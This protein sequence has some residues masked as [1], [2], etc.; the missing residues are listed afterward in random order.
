MP[1]VNATLCLPFTQVEQII[2]VLTETVHEA[3]QRTCFPYLEEADE[4]MSGLEDILYP[5]LYAKL[6]ESITVDFALAQVRFIC[7][8]DATPEDEDE[9]DIEA[10]DLVLEPP[11]TCVISLTL[12]DSDKAAFLSCL[13][14]E[15]YATEHVSVTLAPAPED[16]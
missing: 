4:V 6:I 9:L 16:E 5:L 11:E 12:T 15:H 3:C 8:Y 13:E 7:R 1:V 14:L 10:L 2:A